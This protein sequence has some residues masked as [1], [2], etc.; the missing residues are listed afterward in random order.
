MKKQ[1]GLK[2]EQRAGRILVSG[3]AILPQPNN[4]G[5]RVV[6]KRPP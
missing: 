1:S 6:R 5:I 3:S 4:V 2:N